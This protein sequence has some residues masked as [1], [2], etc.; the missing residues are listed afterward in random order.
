MVIRLSSS[1]LNHICT[2]RLGMMV[3]FPVGG[4]STC[5]DSF[6]RIPVEAGETPL[7]MVHLAGL[8]SA[9]AI[10]ST[11]EILSHIPGDYQ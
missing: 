1:Y 11:G 4:D 10:I 7:A 5:P 9:I 6:L 3:S 2:L 8:V